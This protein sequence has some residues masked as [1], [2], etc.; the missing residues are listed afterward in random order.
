M[1]IKKH[2]IHISIAPSIYKFV[3]Q[4][5]HDY[6]QVVSSSVERIFILMIGLGDLL[7]NW[8]LE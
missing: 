7:F 3:N 2:L 4:I 8:L 1:Y 6:K 5:S